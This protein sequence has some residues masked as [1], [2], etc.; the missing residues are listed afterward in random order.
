[1]IIN[2]YFLIAD[3]ILNFAYFSFDLCVCAADCGKTEGG[4]KVEML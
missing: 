2:R 3:G 4:E 1:M